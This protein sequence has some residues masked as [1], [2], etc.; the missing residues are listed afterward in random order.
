MK[1][2]VLKI[3]TEYLSISFFSKV[4]YSI[5]SDLMHPTMSVEL[6]ALDA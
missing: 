3:V 4:F 2:Y 1:V 6:G 5:F